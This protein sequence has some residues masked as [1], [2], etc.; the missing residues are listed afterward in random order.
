MANLKACI[1]PICSNCRWFKVCVRQVLRKWN[2]FT[3]S[4]KCPKCG[5]IMSKYGAQDIPYYRCTFV[6]CEHGTVYL[7]KNNK[8]HTT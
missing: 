2:F 6:F 3:I 8:L 7:W 1:K 4:P 5:S